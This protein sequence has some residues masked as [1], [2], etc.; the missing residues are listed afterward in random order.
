MSQSNLSPF[1][2]LL[3]LEARSKASATGLPQ[4]VEI[5]EPWSGI[6]F[7]IGDVQLVSAVGD[8]N[9]I[10][11]FPKVTTIPGTK[12]WV[13]GMANIRGNLIPIIDLNGYLGKKLTHVNS[14]SRVLIINN[15]DLWAGL[16]VDQVMGLKHF[17]EDE[18]TQQKPEIDDTLNSYLSIEYQKDTENWYVF[19]MKALVEN[20]EFI[21]VS[22]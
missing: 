13:K 15:A 10:L 19:S 20:P 5:R 18:E 4:Q 2:S 8:V 9:E 7:K 11:H 14:R 12:S 1:D 6:G 17:F 21:Q 22:I 16:L 3:D